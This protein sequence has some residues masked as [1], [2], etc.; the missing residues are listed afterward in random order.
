MSRI[1][2]IAALGAVAVS[3]LVLGS[4]GLREIL[5]R[6]IDCVIC[7]G[8]YSLFYPPSDYNAPIA[9]AR[10]TQGRAA[11]YFFPSYVGP[12][13]V[14]AFQVPSGPEVGVDRFECEDN[15]TF[16]PMPGN[17]AVNKVFSRYGDGVILGA[18]YMT[19]ENAGK[20]T[21]PAC[22]VVFRTSVDLLLVVS[23]ASQL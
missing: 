21:R 1:A 14:E 11:L 13:Y 20:K 2:R 18:V 15:I 19:P 9:M 17:N 8:A 23:R 22:Q 10:V 16:K 6:Q 3:M 12:Y 7:R 4:I 5:L